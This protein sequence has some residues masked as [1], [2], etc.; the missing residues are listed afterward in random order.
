MHHV[1]SLHTVH[2]LHTVIHYT[3]HTARCTLTHYTH[4]ALTTH[5]TFTTHYTLYSL[6]TRSPPMY[7]LYSYY[8]HYPHCTPHSTLYT[9][10]TLCIHSTLPPGHRQYCTIL[11]ILTVHSL[12]TRSPPMYPHYPHCTLTPHSTIG[13]RQCTR[14]IP[15]ILTVLTIH[16]STLHT[17]HQ[18]TANADGDSGCAASIGYHAKNRGVAPLEWLVEIGSTPCDFD[19]TEMAA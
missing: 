10:S 14:T 9:H 6:H 16:H 5:C 11:T 13:H 19:P 18:V 4:C 12:H 3:L 2:S 7:S 8:P 17:P 15:T 1:P